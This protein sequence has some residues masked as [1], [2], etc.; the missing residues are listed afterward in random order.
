MSNYKRYTWENKKSKLNETNMNN[1]ETGIVENKTSISEVSNKVALQEVSINEAK[2]LATEAKNEALNVSASVAEL[3]EGKQDKLESGKNIKTLNGESLLGE[4]DI[5]VA[6]PDSAHYVYSEKSLND[7]LDTGIYSLTNAK[8]CPEETALNGTL[9]V[10]H[11]EDDKVEQQW[12][13]DTNNAYRLYSNATPTANKFYVND[14]LVPQGI[15]Q[16]EA[17]KEYN[18]SGDLIGHIEIISAL[19][20]AAPTKIRLKGVNIKSDGEYAIYYVPEKK[21]LTVE[22]FANTSNYLKVEN[23]ALTTAAVIFSNSDLTITGAGHLDLFANIAHGLK[24]SELVINGVPNI[25]IDV[26][27]DAIHASKFL[28]ITGGNIIVNNAN[29]V[30]SAGAADDPTKNTVELLITGGQFTI[31]KCKEA[32]F[33]GK[34]SAGNYKLLNSTFN[35]SAENIGMMF[36]EESADNEIQCY[37]TCT[38]AGLSSAQQIEVLARTIILADEYEAPVVYYIDAD[39]NRQDI[40]LD[41]NSYC[42]TGAEEGVYYKI[43]GNISGKKFYTTDKKINIALNGVYYNSNV[44]DGEV[45]FDYQNTGSRM[46]INFTEGYINYIN[47]A[48]GILF[49]SGNNVAL[50]AKDLDA[51]ETAPQKISITYLSCP[52]GTVMLACEPEYGRAAIAGDGIV[53]VTNSKCG[54]EAGTLWLGNEYVDN[55][56]ADWGKANISLYLMNNEVDANIHFKQSEEAKKYGYVYIPY[57]L[58]GTCVLGSNLIYADAEKHWIDAPVGKVEDIF[59]NTPIVYTT[60]DVSSFEINNNIVTYDPVYEKEAGKEL[61]VVAADYGKWIV[62]KSDLSDYYTKAEVAENFV[63]K[64]EYNKL[65]NELM[66]KKAT[67]TLDEN[68]S[69]IAI[70]KYENQPEAD[71]EYL[72][73]DALTF[74]YLRDGDFGYPCIDGT[75]QLNFK[76][77]LL[78][79]YDI[80]IPTVEGNYNKF[81]TPYSTCKDN[82]YRFT[83]GSSDLNIKLAAGKEADLE[84]Y[85]VTYNLNLPAGYTGEAPIVTVYRTED[86]AL[87]DYQGKVLEF[88]ENKCVDFS[89]HKSTGYKDKSVGADAQVNFTVKA[90]NLP[91]GYVLSVSGAKANADIANGYKATKLKADLEITIAILPP[92]SITYNQGTCE[93]PF[94]DNATSVGQGADLTFAIN[95]QLGTPLTDEQWA[96]A[97]ESVMCNGVDLKA[98][99]INN[100]SGKKKAK[101]L[102]EGKYVTGDIVVT[103]KSIN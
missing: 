85:N 31:N 23:G 7:L 101:Y 84:A 78:G 34:S 37:D 35:I 55:F 46:Q 92:V 61:Q 36:Q 71:V 18:L 63:S 30:F 51:T 48:D 4:G 28:R 14:E 52:N 98:N 10:K 89:Y 58:L 56:P 64:V 1:I 73:K 2:T 6:E 65:A 62:Y 40:E 88:V 21:K 5:V 26:V 19:E 102:L 66:P 3:Q 25:T 20:P 100:D 75:G 32:V 8:D 42:L 27:H 79:D 39:G 11:L 24:A 70:L 16:L 44:A 96:N 82:L 17:G 91:E 60:A 53:Y 68:I 76:P 41:G 54:V 83:K 97:I 93:Y 81:K 45:L 13:S 57:Y 59:D 69:D 90:E 67:I 94:A 77:T 74:V 80:I 43:S 29:D 99:L 12:M 47:K 86:A 38:W 15:V 72:V 95:H 22:V 33:Q 103:A 49:K 50:K 87:G 9:K